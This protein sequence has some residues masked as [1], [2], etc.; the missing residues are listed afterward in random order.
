VYPAH[1]KRQTNTNN[2]EQANTN[3]IASKLRA[4]TNKNAKQEHGIA[5][6]QYIHTEKITTFA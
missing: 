4:K 1:Q 5:R 6:V 3:K 2:K